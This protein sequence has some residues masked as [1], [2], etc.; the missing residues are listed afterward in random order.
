MPNN[1]KVFL[2]PLYN[3]IWKRNRVFAIRIHSVVYSIDVMHYHVR[4]KC[5]N[6]IRIV[7]IYLTWSLGSTSIWSFKEVPLYDTTATKIGATFLSSRKLLRYFVD[8]LPFIKVFPL[9]NAKS[10]C[11]ILF[12]KIWNFRYSAHYIISIISVYF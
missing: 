11:D 12:W 10:A 2:Q 5:V 7:L 8:R 9:W 1:T 6:L 4:F 3:L